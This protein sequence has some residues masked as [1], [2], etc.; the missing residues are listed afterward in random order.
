M[1]QSLREAKSAL[2]DAVTRAQVRLAPSKT[3]S[4]PVLRP[5][6]PFEA[7]SGRL[8]PLQN[9]NENEKPTTMTVRFANGFETDPGTAAIIRQRSMRSV[10]ATS[11]R[12][13][14]VG[15]LHKLEMLAAT[16]TELLK[17]LAQVE[18]RQRAAAHKNTAIAAPVAIARRPGGES[19]GLAALRPQPGAQ[20]TQPGSEGNVGEHS[21]AGGRSTGKGTEQPAEEAATDTIFRTK[22]KACKAH[23]QDSEFRAAAIDEADDA[24]A[25]GREL[26]ELGNRDGAL[27]TFAEALWL[28]T[29]VS[30]LEGAEGLAVVMAIARIKQLQSEHEAALTNLQ[31]AQAIRKAIGTLT[32][33]AGA[34]LLEEIGDLQLRVNGDMA[35]AV[36]CL[37]QARE[38]RIATRTLVSNE[39]AKLLKRLGDTFL[40]DDARAKKAT[41]KVPETA[42]SKEDHVSRLTYALACFTRSAEVSLT[43]LQSVLLPSPSKHTHL[44]VQN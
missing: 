24:A 18:R 40:A 13:D 43:L 41:K 8:A 27:A 34:A 21:S 37:K 31:E 5:P 42:A 33:P 36:S 23:A 25:K 12:D 39:G 38:I 32:T 1:P 20:A 16:A 3:D 28:R 17:A 4:G 19:R 7:I 14:I 26:L 2:Q 35:A 30:E 15:E 9:Q 22:A 29:L 11:D 6:R 10:G 44:P